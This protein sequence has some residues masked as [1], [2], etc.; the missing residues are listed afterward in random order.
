MISHQNFTNSVYYN[1][2]NMRST[3]HLWVP[4]FMMI[5]CFCIYY[6]IETIFEPYHTVVWYESELGQHNETIEI[7]GDY[8]QQNWKL[9]L[10]NTETV[11]CAIITLW[12]GCVT[13]WVS[14]M[15]GQWGSWQ[16][17]FHWAHCDHSTVHDWLHLSLSAE[18]CLLWRLGVNPHPGALWRLGVNPHPGAL[19]RPVQE[20]P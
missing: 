3:N 1:Y 10:E 14:S 19:W 18:V 5:Y 17:W 11:F 13:D 16:W 7:S 8:V 2:I 12:D 4:E 15:W 9:N 20:P 6:V